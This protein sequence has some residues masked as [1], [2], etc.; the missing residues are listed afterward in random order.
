MKKGEEL[1]ND[2]FLLFQDFLVTETGLYFD[3]SQDH[4]LL[5]AL[6]ERRF[7]KGRSTF[8]EYYN[9]LHYHPEGR[10]ELK[11]LLLM[12]TTGE[13]YFFRNIAQFEVLMRDVLPEIIARKRAAGH[14]TI[15]I[16]SA[17]CSRGDEAYSVAIALMEVLPDYRD[18]QV[19]LQG[20]DIN[21]DVLEVA[22]AAVFTAK[23]IGELPAELANKYFLRER[24]EYALNPDVK[25]LANFFY[26][27]LARDSFAQEGMQGVD[28]IFCRNV[29]IYFNLETTKALIGRFY[30]CLQEGGY[31]FL[32]HSETLW[33][34]NH[35]FRMVEYPHTFIYRKDSAAGTPV[36][37]ARP[38]ASALEAV[39]GPVV[40]PSVVFQG[41]SPAVLSTNER[42]S[43][44]FLG[45]APL[46]TG[47]IDRDN[48][49]ALLLEAT[50][51]FHNKQYVEALVRLDRIIA[52][53]E[54]HIRAIFLKAVIYADQERY[55]EAVSYCLTIVSRDALNVEA[56]LLLA[57]LKVKIGKLSEA[58]DFFRRVMYISPDEPL[59]YFHLANVYTAQK[60]FPRALLELKNAVRLLEKNAE[61]E[62]V[63][64]SEGLSCGVLLRVCKQ[65]MA[66]LQG[67]GGG[68]GRV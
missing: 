45:E 60:K 16:W 43:A 23:D 20:T 27:N 10:G 51:F 11:E 3:N 53:G 61:N 63:K 8:R 26:H 29:T 55:D 15:K 44:P 33:Q 66:S 22:R 58:E 28:I 64:F 34:I 7:Q 4:S 36:S 2:D 54:A 21:R 37:G 68:K 56:T 57:T 13:T 32:G 39:L 14:R 40:L 35:R 19:T 49:Q 1:S 46:Q 5:S 65:R 48:V 12:I 62:P 41:G 47:K 18:W 9:Y 25:A 59:T 17:G 31:L 52:R 42:G 38:G 24:N 30:D 67:V 50:Y 6:T